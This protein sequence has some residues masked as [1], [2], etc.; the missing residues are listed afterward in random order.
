[1]LR[2]KGDFFMSVDPHRLGLLLGVGN[3]YPLSY[4]RG[5]HAPCKGEALPS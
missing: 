5:G 4:K 2:A 3:V 1:M